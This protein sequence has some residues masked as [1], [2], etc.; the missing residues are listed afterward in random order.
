MLMSRF[1]TNTDLP[2]L[3]KNCISPK[4]AFER[5]QKLRGRLYFLPTPYRFLHRTA[6]CILIGWFKK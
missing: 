3:R 2:P 4:D 6:I 1:S 5:L